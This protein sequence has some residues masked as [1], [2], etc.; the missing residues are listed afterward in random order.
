MRLAA[1]LTHHQTHNKAG[2]IDGKRAPE[3]HSFYHDIVSTLQPA[4][5]WLLLGPGSA[6]DELVKH[7]RSHHP[8]LLG[9]I[10]GVES[11]DHP[12]EPQI[13]A[14]ARKFFRAADRMLP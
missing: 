7:I 3:N 12:T 9:R 11:A 1:T 10:V 6:K 5:E 4:Q 14:H 8:Q 2:T 13:L